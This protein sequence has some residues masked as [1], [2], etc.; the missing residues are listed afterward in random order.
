MSDDHTY[1]GWTNYETW[2]VN[3]WLSDDEYFRELA[4]DASDMYQAEIALKDYVEELSEMTM[5]GIF[6][7]SKSY[8]I[9]DMFSAALSEV[10]WHE[11]AEHY[12]DDAEDMDAELSAHASEGRFKNRDLA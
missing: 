1:N 12:R 6:D 7:G 11:I 2:N 5:P 10:N 8:F 3:L 4:A 9:G